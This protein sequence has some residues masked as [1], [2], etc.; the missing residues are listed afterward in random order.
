M[1]LNIPE[2]MKAIIIEDW[3]KDPIVQYNLPIPKPQSG[4]VLIKVMAVPI[5]PADNAFLKG[6]YST[7]RKP[8]CS[9]G[10]EG[11]G[12]VVQNGGGIIGWSIYF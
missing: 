5:N 6:K 1:S 8:P 10:L 11:S 3:K 12:I 2:K 4:Q 7:K 9:P